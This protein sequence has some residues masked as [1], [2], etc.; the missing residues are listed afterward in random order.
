MHIVLGATGHVGSAVANTLLDQG[1]PVT[2][3]TR[4]VEKAQP[5]AVRGAHVARLDVLDT[6]AARALFRRGRTLF[7]LNP[8]AS[9]D[10]DTA[11]EERKTVAALL[12]ALVG[13]G[14]ER[15]VAQ[16]TFGAQPGARNGDLGVLHELEEG[17]RAQSI[18][19]SIVRGA[20]FL[21]NWDFSLTSAREDGVVH[22]FFPPDFELPMVAPQDLG[23]FAA[24]LLTAP[25][26][27]T[28][29]YSVEGPQRYTARDVALAF[30]QALGRPVEAVSIPREQ[31]LTTM[32][33]MGFS[34]P[35]AESF[36]EMTAV[37]MRGEFPPFA[38]TEH[39]ATTLDTYARQWAAVSS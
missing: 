15:V 39:G 19:T 17:L 37:T 20:Y 26:P 25:V 27:D 34:K 9:P 7:L 10:S 18:P 8:P 24:R 13:S 30:A 11:F 22:T 32:Q 5:F 1:E 36:A 31:W 33:Q 23:R 16:S 3:V 21:S 2:V 14:L 28:G 12:A 38:E 29:L 35:A 4:S 6:S